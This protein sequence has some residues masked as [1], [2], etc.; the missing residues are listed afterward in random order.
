MKN[1]RSDR[2]TA[3]STT[4]NKARVDT[5]VL[6]KRQWRTE[7]GGGVWGFNLPARNS[8]VLQSRTGLQVERKIFSVP[9][10]TT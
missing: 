10:P 4:E 9:I 1:E 5:A 8:K 2:Q 6:D 7:G 3:S